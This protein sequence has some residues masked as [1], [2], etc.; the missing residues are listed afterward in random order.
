MSHCQPPTESNTSFGHLVF[1]QSGKSVV[2]HRDDIR[3]GDVVVIENAYFRGK[4]ALGH[5]STDIVLQH[6]VALEFEARKSKA[7]IAQ[8][9]EH[10]HSHPTLE[11]VRYAFLS[12]LYLSMMESLCSCSYTVTNWTICRVDR[13]KSS[14][15]SLKPF[16]SLSPILLIFWSL[17]VVV[18]L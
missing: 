5:Y 3:P 15:R 4:K 17:G 13:S 1:D 11:S 16:S 6:G 10:T 9:G 8:V 12:L 14:E 18:Y 7:R 2:T